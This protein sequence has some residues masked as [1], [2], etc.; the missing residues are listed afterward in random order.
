M[1]E[2]LVFHSRSLNIHSCVCV[3]ANLYHFLSDQKLKMRNVSGLGLVAIQRQMAKVM[4][5][6]NGLIFVAVV[7]HTLKLDWIN[8][9]A[10][11]MFGF[12]LRL[13]EIA[14]FDQ[15][16]CIDGAR[17]MLER[18]M[19]FLLHILNRRYE[20]LRRIMSGGEWCFHRTNWLVDWKTA[21]PF[22]RY[23]HHRS[24]E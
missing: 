1:A 12:P 5:K 7:L 22:T 21:Q 9:T 20:T 8:L 3:Q 6:I 16:Q 24:R 4:W 17:W 15:C 23:F 19:Q 2:H 14:Q 10:A 13:P 11:A 18:R